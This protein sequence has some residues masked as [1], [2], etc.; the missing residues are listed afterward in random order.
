MTEPDDEDSGSDLADPEVPP[1]PRLRVMFG[2]RILDRVVTFVLW[3]GVIFAAGWFIHWA[4]VP[5]AEAVSGKSTSFSANVSF[6]FSATLAL[7]NVGTFMWGRRHKSDNERLRR[8]NEDLQRR[9][10][11]SGAKPRKARR[12]SSR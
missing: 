7:T 12:G 5:L 6:T 8:R 9:L 10:Q 4:M 1:A 2:L 11:R 3:I